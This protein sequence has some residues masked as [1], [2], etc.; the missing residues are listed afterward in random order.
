MVLRFALVACLLT[1]AL[2]QKTNCTKDAINNAQQAFN[3]FL[4]LDNSITWNNPVGLA[5]AVQ[6]KFITSDGTSGLVAVCNAYN[7]YLKS[8]GDAN[9]D[10]NTCLDPA[11]IISNDNDPA[12]GYGYAG[13]LNMIGYQCGA[14]LY[15]ALTKWN[16]IKNT[17]NVQNATLLDCL[18]NLH[19]D[20]QNNVTAA[21]TYTKTAILCWQQQ[22]TQT[23]SNDNE[24]SYYACQTIRSYTA[25]AYG[26]CNDRCL[27][28][29]RPSFAIDNHFD[30]LQKREQ[31]A[32]KAPA[33]DKALYEMI[34][35]N[36]LI[37]E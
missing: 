34:K 9:V 23:C 3:Q 33:V 16:C 18:R 15:P 20:S 35:Q 2:G 21:C 19:L 28:F 14:G 32:M 31:E 10:Y 6:N 30:E 1:V 26:E 17:Y 7:I 25:A 37:V 22:F 27:I 12:T 4:G 11:F 13:V 5:L 8:M 29:A 36:Y 24:V